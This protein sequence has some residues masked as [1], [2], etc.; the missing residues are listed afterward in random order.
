MALALK[1]RLSR[2][3][4][5]GVLIGLTGLIFGLSPLGGDLEE[6]LGLSLLFKLRGP[7]KAPSD[8]IIVSIDKISADHLGLP[9]D[10]RKWPRTLHARLVEHLA[11]EG[12]SVIAFDMYFD[13][14]RSPGEDRVF[15]EAVGKAGNVVLCERIRSEKISLNGKE[16]LPSGDVSIVRL[17]PPVTPIG[18]NASALAPFPLPKVPVR[19][20]QYWTFV[21]GAGE[22]PTLPVVAFQIF[23]TQVYDEF[24]SLLKKASSYPLPETLP[25]KE[26]LST[27]GTI[28]KTILAIRNIFEKEPAGSAGMLNWMSR[29]K[30]AP[31]DLPGQQRLA[32]LVKMYRNPDSL[33]LNYYGP[34]GTITTVPYYRM[35]QKANG[36]GPPSPP[37]MKGKVVFVGL[38]ELLEFEQKDGF[39][40][41]FS[42]EDGRDISGVEIAATAFAN[43]IEDLPLRS[44][45][46]AA[47]IALLLWWGL[48]V[49]VLCRVFSAP[50]AAGGLIALGLLY[51]FFSEHQFA[52]LG[53]WYPLVSPLFFQMPLAFFGAVLSKYIEANRERRNITKAFRH[54]V[55]AEVAERLAEDVAELKAG[56]RLVHGVCICTDVEHYSSL[57]ETM[58][59]RQLGRL[60]NEYY[61]RV[62]GP[63]KEHGGFISDVIGDSTLALW[64]SS[65]PADLPRDEACLAAL[66]IDSAVREFNRDREGPRLRTRIG[67]HA[68]QLLLGNVGAADHYEYRPVGDMVNTAT[69]IEGLNKHLG[70]RILV[71]GEVMRHAEGLL[72]RE[73]G[74]FLPEGKTRPLVVH[75]LICAIGEADAQRRECCRLFQEGL[76]LFRRQLWDE[77][78]VKFGEAGD[79]MEEDGPSRF[80]LRLCEEFRNNPPGESWDGVV[81]MER[82]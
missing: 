11:K 75:E 13:E 18:E 65:D 52:S 79:C 26:M 44:L 30:T 10:T 76:S 38:S 57:A 69:R 21:T 31:G 64:I 50:L 27:P 37:S 34:P 25:G 67:V 59:L 54:Y 46:P 56:G 17:L 49:G 82:K 45:G 51:L 78:G 43:L 39:Y 16:S 14:A 6:T 68:G 28:E 1:S 71:S 81:R 9:Y 36:E 72:A 3:I 22:T 12:A 48:L 55:P 73:I 2:A 7:R 63:V 24:L 20:S 58:E 42:Q 60:M 5:L 61:E 77:A 8:V 35:I 40:T 29:A 62:F 41:V 53:R 47:H 33:Y 70:T 15:A 80:Y 19:V 23:S 4:T 74:A 32:S 66:G